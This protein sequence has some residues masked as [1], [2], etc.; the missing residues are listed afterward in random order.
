MF[1]FNKQ[2]PDAMFV[3][4]RTAQRGHLGNGWN[5]NHEITPDRV[6]DFRDLDFPDRSFKLVVFDPPHVRS[7]SGTSIMG[8]LYGSLHPGRWKQDLRRGFDEL[9]RV[10]DN[11]GTLIF[12][13]SEVQIPLREVLSC[14]KEEPVFGHPT[15]KHGKT[16]WCAFFKNEGRRKRS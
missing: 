15:S 9:W 2:H 12:K 4:N 1:W 8:R 7:L 16:I 11:H 6:M 10:L 14:F 5:P 13:W 3:D